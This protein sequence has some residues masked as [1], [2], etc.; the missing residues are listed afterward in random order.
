MLYIAKRNSRYALQWVKI[1]E[2]GDPR[3]TD[4][5]HIDHPNFLWTVKTLCQAVLVLHLDVKI[6]C[7]TDNR[8][9]AFAL[10]HLHARIKDRLITA[11]FVDDQT[12]YHLSLVFLQKLHGSVKLCKH[13]AAVD[14]SDQK[15]R[16]FCHLRHSHVYDIL[17]FEVDL[18][19]ASCT[20]DHDDIILCCKYIKCFHDVRDKF[21]LVSKIIPCAHCAKDFSVYNDLRT[22]IVGRFQKDR[23]HKDGRFD[24]GSLCLHDLRSS[25]L[26]SF[27]CDKGIQCHIL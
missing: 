20:F 1:C 25:H 22:H 26:Q 24:P 15:D 4:D 12:L 17:F 10:Q 8:D 16:C 19:R 13:T 18:C 11:E 7:D 2:I 14:I 5:C 9:P 21:F 6:R 23:V 27:L 3:H